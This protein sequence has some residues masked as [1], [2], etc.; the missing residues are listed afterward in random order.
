MKLA[1]RL[2]RKKKAILERCLSLT[3]EA[4]PQETA[5]FL[6][7]EQDPFANPIG[8][9]L[10]SGL[11]KIL[12]GLISLT[13]VKELDAPLD[14]VIRIQ[15]VQEFPPSAALAFLPM[16]KRSIRE[17]TPDEKPPSDLSADLREFEARLDDLLLRAFD[18][19]TRCREEISG[20]R[21]K[22]ARAEKERLARV[23]MAM[24]GQKT[25]ER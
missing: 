3:L 24:S 15:A 22:E 10:R 17:H 14:A 19:Y 16:L 8:H 9:A 18:L 20:L 12:D 13:D 4:Y 1:E 11:E 25:G 5:D 6:R 7:D 23:V 21:V 2:V